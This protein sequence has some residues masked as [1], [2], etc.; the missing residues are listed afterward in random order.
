MD[1]RDSRLLI[2]AGGEQAETLRQEMKS[3]V[4][5]EWGRALGPPCVVV[6]VL[7]LSLLRHHSVLFVT[8]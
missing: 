3:K 7:G 4:G 5:S 6:A 2:V 8:W 1:T